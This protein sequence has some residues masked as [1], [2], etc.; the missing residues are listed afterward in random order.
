M[1]TQIEK[2]KL[3]EK[4]RRLYFQYRGDVLAVAREAGLEDQLEYV[5]KVTDKIKRSFN[6]SVNFEIACFVTDAL[7]AGREQRLILMEDRVQELLN[8]EIVVSACHMAPVLTYKFENVPHYKCS[9]C[10]ADC[11]IIKQDGTSDRAVVQYIDRMR[12]ED[13]LIYKF[14]VT[15][16]FISQMDATQKAP[17]GVLPAGIIENEA[18]TFSE[19]DALMLQQIQDMDGTEVSALRKIIQDKL[20]N[21]QKDTNAE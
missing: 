4:L 7:L 2:F 11:N 18:K 1:S 6:H 17:A 14:M 15:M 19:D 9:D 13:E 20:N 16:G 3:E 10:E 12:K 21:T 8:K 5:R